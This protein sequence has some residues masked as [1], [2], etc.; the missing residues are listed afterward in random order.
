MNKPPGLAVEH[1]PT[2][3]RSRR[4]LIGMYLLVAFLYLMALYL[5]MP[6]LPTYIQSKSENLA[7]VGII[8][9]QYGLWQAIIRLP[10][11]IAADWVGRRKPF[12]MVGLA[13]VGVSAWVWALAVCSRLRRRSGQPPS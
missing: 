12:I 7:L 11:G 2:T 3:V 5:Y 9:A 10:L 13:L 1:I 4:F 8:L 6:T